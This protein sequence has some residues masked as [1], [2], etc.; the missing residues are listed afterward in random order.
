[1]LVA[2]ITARGK[3]GSTAPADSSCSISSVA[4]IALYKDDVVFT[5]YKL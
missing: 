3:T 4:S 5:G 2:L 1:M